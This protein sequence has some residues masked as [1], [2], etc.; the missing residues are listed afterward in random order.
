[1]NGSLKN[2]AT[3]TSIVFGL[4]ILLGILIKIY[5]AQIAQSDTEPLVAGYGFGNPLFIAISLGIFFVGGLTVG[6][7][8]DRVILKEPIT[9]ALLAMGLLS[10]AVI[11]GMAETVFLVSFARSGAWGSF[12]TTVAGG[13]ISTVAGALIGER[14]RTPPE[15][16]ALARGALTI[17]LG[18][19]VVGPFMLLTR[20]GMPWIVVLIVVLILL[21]LLGLAYYLFTKGSPLE[22]EINDISISP[23]RRRQR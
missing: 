23:D 12:L 15:D 1:M 3:G 10:I 11:F 6:F 17:G 18:L 21:S 16:D 22:D 8:E 2:I 14:M 7:M 4:Q 5:A 19:V 13:I 20:Y 9:V